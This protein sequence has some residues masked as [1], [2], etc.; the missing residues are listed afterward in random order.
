MKISDPVLQ[1]IE[2]KVKY[3]TIVVKYTL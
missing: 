1:N 2:E 3:C